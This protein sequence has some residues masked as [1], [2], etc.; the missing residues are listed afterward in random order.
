MLA[1]SAGNDLNEHKTKSKQKN[2]QGPQNLNQ[3]VRPEVPGGGLLH[4]REGGLQT[5]IDQ[6]HFVVSKTH[7]I[8]NCPISG[9]NR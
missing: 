3:V 6:G 1:D 9:L 8:D 7:V 4:L 2:Q 5:M